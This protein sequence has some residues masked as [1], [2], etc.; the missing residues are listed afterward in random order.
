M[1]ALVEGIQESYL[2]TPDPVTSEHLNIYNKAIVGLME[3]TD[4]TRPDPNG[5][6]FT[7]NW[8]MLYPHLD[9]KQYF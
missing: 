3:A 9:S 6:T 4:M 1:E 2:E 5:L 8:R 7:K